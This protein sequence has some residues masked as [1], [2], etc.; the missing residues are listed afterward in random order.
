MPH[1]IRQR[2]VRTYGTLSL[3]LLKGC[4]SLTDLGEDFGAGL[5]ARE[6]EYLVANEWALTAEDILWRRTK[7]GLHLQHADTVALHACVQQALENSSSKS[8]CPA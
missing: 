6:V 3:D 7:L 5:R 8:P 2:W 4:S 1:Q